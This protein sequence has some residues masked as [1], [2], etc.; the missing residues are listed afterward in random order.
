MEQIHKL[1]YIS[2]SE[3]DD[4]II[5]PRIENRY[6]INR[7]KPSAKSLQKFVLA[8]S[9]KHV[10]KPP[11]ILPLLEKLYLPIDASKTLEYSDNSGFSDG[12]S[13]KPNLNITE[14]TTGSI[15]KEKIKQYSKLEVISSFSNQDQPVITLEEVNLVNTLTVKQWKCKQ[16]YTQKAGIISASKAKRVHDFQISL[17]KCA[18]KDDVSKLVSEIAN[19]N[20]PSYIAPL[21][22]QPQNPRDCSLKHEVT[23]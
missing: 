1:Q 2:A 3:S 18:N 8:I 14:K 16:W 5:F 23:A 13:E 12:E 22:D 21:P 4:N 9:G 19:P 15:M 6:K 7:T 10:H 11:A 20:I 17:K